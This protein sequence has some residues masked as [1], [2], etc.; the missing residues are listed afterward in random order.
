[1]TKGYAIAKEEAKK[2]V[3][4]YG[5]DGILNKHFTEIQERTGVSYTDLANAFDYFRYSPKAAKYRL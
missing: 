2:A 4:K 1:M 3:L 5:I